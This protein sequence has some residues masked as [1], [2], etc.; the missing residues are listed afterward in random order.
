MDD[1][2]R[3]EVDEACLRLIGWQPDDWWP[4]TQQWRAFPPG[5]H[6]LM[7]CSPSRDDRFVVPLAEA[8]RERG[9]SLDIWGGSSGWRVLIG[10]ENLIEAEADTLPE[11]LA[12]A[13]ARAV[14]TETKE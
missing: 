2:T 11:A 8:L 12:L 10:P 9:H 13:A 7:F 4:E 1:H 14:G 3:R 6:I 5:G